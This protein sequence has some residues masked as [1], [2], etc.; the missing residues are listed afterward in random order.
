MLLV[1]SDRG[2]AGG[3]NSN[4]IK[5]AEQLTELLRAEG[6]EVV[7]LRHR[8]QGRGVLPASASARSRS[9]WTGFTDNP[10]YENAKEIARRA[11]RGAS[12]RDDR[13]TGGVDEIHIVYTGS[14]R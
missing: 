10:T 13:P 4:V 7:P 6:K 9:S 8:P 1:T 3:Y 14:S 5:A 11:D 2:L 12:S